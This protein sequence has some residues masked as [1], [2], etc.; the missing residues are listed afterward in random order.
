MKKVRKLTHMSLR[1]LQVQTEVMAARA[2]VLTNRVTPSQARILTE[3]RDGVGT[4]SRLR[5]SKNLG[6]MILYVECATCTC[7]KVAF[8]GNKGST[9]SELIHQQRAGGVCDVDYS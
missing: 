7:A 8:L 2:G 1:W 6:D 4:K 3:V 5:W 9:I